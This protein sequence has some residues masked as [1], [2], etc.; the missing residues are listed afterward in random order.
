MEVLIFSPMAVGMGEAASPS[1]SSLQRTQYNEVM[2]GNVVGF[3]PIV[4]G[5]SFLD[6]FV[7]LG[8]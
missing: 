6:P 7:G 8:R 5:L 2:R 1:F 4:T 3:G